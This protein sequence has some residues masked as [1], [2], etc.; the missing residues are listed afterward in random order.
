M[1][2]DLLFIDE[3]CSEEYTS[4][5]IDSLCVS[6]GFGWD[7]GSWLSPGWIL[8]DDSSFLFIGALLGIYHKASGTVDIFKLIVN[9]CHSCRNRNRRWI[10][11]VLYDRFLYLCVSQ[12]GS[13]HVRSEDGWE[14]G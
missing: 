6:D 14:C 7:T 1:Q 10:F 5:S 9:P 8:V 4:D 12:L 13:D 11:S 3:E 2:P